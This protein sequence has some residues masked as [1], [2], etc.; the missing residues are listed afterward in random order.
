MKTFLKNNFIIIIVLFM[1]IFLSSLFLFDRGVFNG[2]NAKYHMSRIIGAFLYTTCSYRIITILVKAFIGEMLSFI[3][4]PIILLGLYEIIYEN[5]RKWWIFAAGFIGI[6]NSNLVMT[7]IMIVVSGVIILVN[8][9]S[10]IKE[11]NNIII[12][13]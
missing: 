3:F 6:L 13:H 2:I 11:K 1:A 10:I 12:M 4:I 9:K 5:Y 8:I 7:E